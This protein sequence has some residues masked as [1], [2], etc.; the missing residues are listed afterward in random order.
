MRGDPVDV[1]Y[2]RAERG[3]DGIL[4]ILAVA[5][6][7]TTG[8]RIFT[9]HRVVGDTVEV[10]LRGVPPSAGGIRELSHPAAPTIKIADGGVVSRVAVNAR[11]GTRDIAINQGSGGA[12][13]PRPSVIYRP[14]APGPV[15]PPPKKNSSGSGVTSGNPPPSTSKPPGARVANQIEQVRYDFGATVGVWISPDGTYDMIG[16]RKPTP[17]EKRLLDGLGSLL[18]ST[19]AFNT[20]PNSSM[21]AKV[22]E[23]ASLIEEV[24]Q[25]VKLSP[26]LNKKFQTMLNDARALVSST[27]GDPGPP[28]GASGP[29][30]GPVS[31]GSVSADA[32]RVLGQI[33]QA[34]F[35]F[36]GTVGAFI[37]NDGGYE[38]IGTRELT[39]DEKQILDGLTELSNAVKAVSSSSSATP[40][41][42]TAAR[43]REEANAVEQS[44]KR[45]RMSQDLNQ[46]FTRMLQEV[47]AFADALSR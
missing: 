19:R 32:A 24:W 21:G 38:V 20:T 31:S 41:P 42:S 11:N 1:S 37:N 17:D 36:G 8:W 18:N 43:M 13:Q 15:S 6:T 25:R 16:Q 14:A 46:K 12:G 22:M 27:Q 34:Q 39:P 7:P 45:V 5:E 44:W 40:R 9:S 29:P 28:P 2:V 33:Q 35:G 26:E 30:P 4:R 10:R 47:R 3:L 23:D